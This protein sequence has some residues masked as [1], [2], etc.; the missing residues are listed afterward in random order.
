MKNG[1]KNEI[2]YAKTFEVLTVDRLANLPR[3]D[4]KFNCGI[5]GLK[6]SDMMSMTMLVLVARALQQ[7][8]KTAIQI[9]SKRSYDIETKAQSS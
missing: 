8:M 2:T 7:P 9:C 3:A 5:T 4:H 6:A 1:V